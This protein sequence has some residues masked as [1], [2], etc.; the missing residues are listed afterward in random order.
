MNLHRY[1]QSN[2]IL[3]YSLTTL[4]ILISALL[5]TFVIQSFNNPSNLLA[6]GFTGL[7]MIIDN[8]SGGL[9]PVSLGIIL[10][11][12]PAA[13]LCI[14]SI[15]LYF[16]VFSC[17][18]FSLTSLFL[19]VL[20]FQP[21]FNDLFLN[22]IFGGVLYG[23]SICL[24]LKVNASTGGVD[25]IC[26]YFSNRFKKSL[27]KYVFIYNCFL[28][29]LFGFTSSWTNAAY[30]IVF[31]YISNVTIQK[32]YHF[33]DCYTFQITTFKV[34]EIL[35]VYT[36]NYRHGISCCPG[37]GGYSKRSLTVLTTVVA[38]YEVNEIIQLLKSV[39]PQ[40]II[41]VHKTENFVGG[42]YRRP[43]N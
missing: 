2:L 39:D 7:S 42:F 6:S 27:W 1:I 43:I 8:L 26:I 4:T 16:C 38:S 32:F 11:N 15:S 20:N 12:I 24:A 28:I 14:R 5:Q 29:I 13:L 30:S 10:L 21:I 37:Y 3:K 40:V 9:I 18:Q 17:L 23:I 31:Q 19:S 25:F 34:D 33:Y 41:N 22:I 36:K 35:D